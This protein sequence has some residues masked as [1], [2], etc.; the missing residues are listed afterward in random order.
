MAAWRAE[1]ALQHLADE[2][3]AGAG[4]CHGAATA[5][6]LWGGGGLLERVGCAA[7]V[8]VWDLELAQHA[9]QAQQNLSLV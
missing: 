4:V 6:P 2:L 5:G 3:G 9:F 8:S 7:A 1:F